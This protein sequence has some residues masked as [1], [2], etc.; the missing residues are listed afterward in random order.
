MVMTCLRAGPQPHLA[1]Q[2]MLGL[3]IGAGVGVVMVVAAFA[4]LAFLAAA[5]LNG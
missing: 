1:G 4:E 3:L 5:A 2:A